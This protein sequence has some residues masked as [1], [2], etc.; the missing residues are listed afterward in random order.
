M[1]NRT[2]MKPHIDENNIHEPDVFVAMA[3]L[4]DNLQEDLQF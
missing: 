2:F 3:Y 4:N 1:S